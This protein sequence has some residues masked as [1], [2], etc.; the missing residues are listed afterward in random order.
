MSIR[1]LH[2]ADLHLGA[3][4]KSFRQKSFDLQ[5]EAFNAFEKLVNY[6]ANPSNEI[7]ILIIAGDL[8]DSHQPD[9]PLVEKVKD[10]LSKIIEKNIKLYILPGNHDSYSYKNSIYRTAEFPGMIINNP[11]F[12]LIDEI[13][14]KG[15]P[16]FIYSGIYEINNPNKRILENFKIDKKSG[17][18]I[19]ILHGT[20]ELREIEVPERDLPFSYEEF[21]HSG[22][23][24]LALGHF[25]KYL[26]KEINKDYKLAY[27]G[28][29][30]PRTLDE[31]GEKYSLIV[32]IKQ[33]NSIHIEKFQFSKIKAEK[34]T[35][36]LIKEDITNFDDLL[37]LLKKTKN[38][39]LILDLLLEGVLDF[40]INEK[41]LISIIEDFFFFVRITNNAKSVESSFIK[42]LEKEETIRGLFFKKMLEKTGVMKKEKQKILNQ[43]VNLGLRDFIQT[44]YSIPENNI[45]IKES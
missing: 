24:Y 45:K 20:L 27:P 30:I 40:P 12:K 22:L 7:D 8:F 41:D 15:Q 35:I 36:D 37:N 5:Q 6:T 38:P 39:D 4:Y 19:G 1:I 23:N 29:L 2:T 17:A 14:I 26:E 9:R 25:H 10:L 42:Q 13:N 34:R 44:D 3:E 18:H 43:A 31:Y 21:S 16:A 33:N 11:D 32:E 28:S